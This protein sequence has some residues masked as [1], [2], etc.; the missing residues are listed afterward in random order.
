MDGHRASLSPT[1][2]IQQSTSQPP[3]RRWP[4]ILFFTCLA[5]LPQAIAAGESVSIFQEATAGKTGIAWVHENGKSKQRYLPEMTGSGVAIFDYNNDGWM[6]ILLVNSGPNRFYHPTGELHQALYR[7]NRDGTYTD[8]AAAAGLKTEL[9]GMGAAI[10]D[11]DNDGSEDIFVTGIDRCVLYHNNGD[12]TFT[13]ATQASGLRATQWSTSAVWFDFDN[14]GK[15]DLFVAEFADY[16]G[17]KICSLAG[18]YG[19][20]ANNLP[21]AQSYYCHPRLLQSATSHLYRNLGN[22]KFADVTETTGLAF[23]GKAWGAVATD[24]NQDGFLDL[25][26]AN[27]TVP[28]NLW[29][30]RQGHKFEDIALESGV[31][32]SNDGIPRSGMGVDAADF[33]RDGHQDLIVGNIDT[34]TTSLYRNLG[35]ELFDDRNRRTGIGPGTR[36]LSTWGLQFLDYDNDGWPDIVLCNG[37]PDDTADERDN[38]ITY[39][40][41]ILLFRN[42][43]GKAMQNVSPE[44]GPA[45][46]L[47]Y[48]ARGLAVGDL[49][50]DGYPDVVFTENGG[51]PHLLMNSA[52]SGNTWAGL[53]LQPK[54]AAPGAAGAIIRWSAGGKT[55]SVQKTAGGS[56]LSS[57]DP[58]IILGSGKDQIDWIEVRWPRPSQRVDRIEHPRMNQY[59]TIAEGQSTP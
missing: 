58:R 27:D 11:Y 53:K 32:Y 52:A 16:T 39:R 46:R 49:N 3:M 38:G 5:T 9:F 54:M 35:N 41:P 22:G 12:G 36:L 24:I 4:F 6:D 20:S 37:Y 48:T 1:P 14:D 57:H 40:Q 18:S 55:L 15:L 19:G 26:V 17:N 42:I 30:N 44:A 45:F 29:I 8:V 34:E 21:A 7:N 51:P 50:N 47:R 59:T 23:P 25:F 2:I 43:D 10:G 13:D 33:D 28:N 56:F 31:A